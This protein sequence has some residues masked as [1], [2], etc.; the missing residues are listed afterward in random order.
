[1]SDRPPSIREISGPVTFHVP[2]S[3][4]RVIWSAGRQA[5]KTWSR[6]FAALDEAEVRRMLAR[7]VSE[8]PPV[9]VWSGDL[10][11]IGLSVDGHQDIDPL[12]IYVRSSL[13]YALERGRLMDEMARVE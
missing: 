11:L 4:P 1:M 6:K 10:L 12:P 5:G 8:L 7:W 9:L 13:E 3:P 2:W